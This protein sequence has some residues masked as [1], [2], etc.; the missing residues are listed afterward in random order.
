VL[1]FETSEGR[2]VDTGARL[3]PGAGP[4]AP[5]DEVTV[6]Y[7]P[8]DPRR[9]ALEKKLGGRFLGLFLIV[10]GLL[11]VALGLVIGAVALVVTQSPVSHYVVRPFRPASCCKPLFGHRRAGHMDSG[12]RC[13][14]AD[15][16]RHRAKDWSC[17]R[18]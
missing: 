8:A 7:D 10:F 3:R 4:G 2:H 14:M 5:G 18:Q 16:R 6:L 9:A 13:A 12:L 1:R 11:F 17:R 15:D